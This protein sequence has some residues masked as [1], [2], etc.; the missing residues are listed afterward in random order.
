MTRIMRRPEVRPA[1]LKYSQEKL[2]SVNANFGATQG[3]KNQGTLRVVFDEILMT[4]STDDK[5]TYKFFDNSTVRSFPHTNLP[6]NKFEKNES[7]GV[8][9]ISLQAVI[10]SQSTGAITAIYDLIEELTLNKFYGGLLDVYFDNNR[11]VKE[12]SL[13]EMMPQFNPKSMWGA[14]NSYTTSSST[15]VGPPAVQTNTV[16]VNKSGQSVLHFPTPLIIPELMQF[17]M[18]IRVPR[19]PALP[20][21]GADTYL[22]LTAAGFSYI[23]APKANH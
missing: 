17:Y 21:S 23:N 5:Q 8:E 1:G 9:R 11:V 19:V 4:T 18:N 22:R 20:F 14:V 6:T 10:Y 3:Y 7:M 15:T 12:M 2:A 16:T 13:I